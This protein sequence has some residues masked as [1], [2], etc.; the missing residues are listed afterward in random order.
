LSGLRACGA[1]AWVEMLRLLR[2]PTS[3]T[4]LLLVPALQIVLFGTAIQPSGAKVA[5]AVAGPRAAAAALGELSREPGLVL[6]MPRLAPGGAEAAVRAGKAQI[7][8]EIPPPGGG[9]V[10]LVVNAA[11]PNLTALAESRILGAYWRRAAES[12]GVADLAPPIDLQ[13]LYNPDARPDWGF[14]PALVGVIMM[15]SS[16]MFGTLGI[17]REREQGTWE[18]LLALPLGRG[19]LILGK[20]APHVALVTLQGF[21]VLLVAAGLFALPM[22]GAV[23]SLM[24]LMP[25]FAA[26]HLALGH[27]L[28]ARAR[29]QLAALQGAIAFYLP[30]M[31]LSGFLYPREALPRWARIL[32]DALPLT[33]FIRA[34][35]QATLE[36]GGPGAVLMHGVPICLFLGA[37]LILAALRHQPRLD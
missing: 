13:R 16:I 14:L 23:S 32:G 5:V 26:A 29:N 15:I 27:A 17:V 33:H 12:A 31:L 7:G 9:A 37:A 25:P 34:A 36:G 3:F 35:R 20:M 4:L 18:A 24:L 22:R 19:M 1:V 30:C 10:R 6:A 21:V 8:L 11:D 28:A 2:S